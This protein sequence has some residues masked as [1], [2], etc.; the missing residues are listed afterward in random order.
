LSPVAYC[1]PP[2][3]VAITIRRRAAENRG[4]QVVSTR[5]GC[6]VG[7]RTSP[8]VG[9]TSRSGGSVRARTSGRPRRCPAPPPHPH[10]S[11]GSG[12]SRRLCREG[13]PARRCAGA[14]RH[15]D[16]GLQL[17]LEHVLL[18]GR[19][20]ARSPRQP[21][22]V[23]VRVKARVRQVCPTKRRTRPG[24]WPPCAPTAGRPFV[25]ARSSTPPG[26]DTSP[27]N[28]PQAGGTVSGV[29]SVTA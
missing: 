22:D 13:S 25:P 19:V 1:G 6:P 18:T 12:G 28:G 8:A 2:T 17:L 10:R 15:G 5:D 9:R 20:D 14:L 23:A 27:L 24:A 26:E 29:V 7:R 16:P 11:R 3:R 21:D 4:A